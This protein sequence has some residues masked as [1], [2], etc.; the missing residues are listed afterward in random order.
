MTDVL[1]APRAADGDIAGAR[2]LLLAHPMIGFPKSSR[3]A[4]RSLGDAYEPFESLTSL[5]EEGVGFIVV[6]PGA[7]FDDYVVEIPEDDVA[8]LGL[9]S[10][11]DV[12]VLA[13]VT[14][15][16]GTSPTVNLMGPI[17]VNRRTDQAAQ[18]VLQDSPYGVSVPVD[19]RSS[20]AGDEPST[21]A[22]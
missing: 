18:L 19:A 6:P 20:C 14:R 22:L 3:F 8:R 17:V 4:L 9:R 5:D 12:E 2:K 21:T 13:L 16:A 15:R 10:S 7:L 1:T 11:E